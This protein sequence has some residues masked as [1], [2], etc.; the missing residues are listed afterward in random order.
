MTRKRYVKLLMSKGYSR[1]CAN[2]CAKDLVADGGSY[3]QEYDDLE[4]MMRNLKGLNVEEMREVVQRFTRS[5]DEAIPKFMEAVART[6]EAFNA[7]VAAFRE[8]YRAAMEAPGKQKEEL[9][10]TTDN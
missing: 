6:I 7:G 4:E 2:L 5:L 9:N 1:N 8:A 3:Q 10:E